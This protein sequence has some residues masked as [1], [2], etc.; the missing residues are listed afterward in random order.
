MSSEVEISFNLNHPLI[1]NDLPTRS[2]VIQKLKKIGAKKV[3]T[4]LFQVMKFI[5]PNGSKDDTLR[6]RNEGRY[7]TLT[8][9]RKDPETKYKEEFE[10][11]IDNFG[12]GVQLL[13]ALGA[14]EN[15]F[16]EKIREIWTYKN[17]EIVFDDVPGLPTIIEIECKSLSS[18]KKCEEAVYNTA[19]KVGIYK[20][21]D[22][23]TKRSNQLYQ[24]LYGFEL[25]DESLPMS[26]MK[27]IL[28]KKC[29]KNKGKMMKIITEQLKMYKKLVKK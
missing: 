10:V 24:E 12:N 1:N 14:K 25:H 4:Y 16:Y 29:K 13:K 6:I 28:G 9:K 3:N 20:E 23:D 22:E 2:E 18:V 8:Y 5:P 7:V 11:I 17:T 26:Q 27:S 21:S 19:R 15:Y